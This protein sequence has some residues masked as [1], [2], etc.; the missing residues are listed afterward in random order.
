MEGKIFLFCLKIEQN[1]WTFVKMVERQSRHLVTINEF[2]H[3]GLKF[4]S[5]IKT[6]QILQTSVPLLIPDIVNDLVV[7]NYGTLFTLFNSTL[8]GGLQ[9]IF[10]VTLSIDYLII[11]GKLCKLKHISKHLVNI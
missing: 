11:N 10:T 6:F 9:R 4:P 3:Q 7:F 8:V 1:V 5:E 2:I